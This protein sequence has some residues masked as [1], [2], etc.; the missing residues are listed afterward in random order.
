MPLSP[1][2]MRAKPSLQQKQHVLNDA[3][4]GNHD[5]GLEVEGLARVP[6][7]RNLQVMNARVLGVSPLL[8]AEAN[9]DDRVPR[10]R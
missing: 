7:V 1:K 9:G 10:E 4:A 6:P 8:H 5:R 3:H 2:I